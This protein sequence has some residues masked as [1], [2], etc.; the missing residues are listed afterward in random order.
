M[1]NILLSEFSL[2]AALRCFVLLYLHVSHFQVEQSISVVIRGQVLLTNE[3]DFLTPDFDT[4]P[5][6]TPFWVAHLGSRKPLTQLNALRRR[7][8]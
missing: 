4:R 5:M 7:L 3:A 8:S 2:H 1:L 6:E